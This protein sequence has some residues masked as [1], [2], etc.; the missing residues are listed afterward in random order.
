MNLVV[1]FYAENSGTLDVVYV[2]Y[3]TIGL[4]EYDQLV[5]EN[6]SLTI[7]I[8]RFVS[9]V[10]PLR[11]PTVSVQ[12]AMKYAR[13]SGLFLH[14]STVRVRVPERG[15][16]AFVEIRPYLQTL[17]DVQEVDICGYENVINYERLLDAWVDAQYPLE[18]PVTPSKLIRQ[19]LFAEILGVVP[20][21]DEWNQMRI[22]QLFAAL[23]ETE[24]NDG[25]HGSF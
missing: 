13:E 18:W 4:K 19:R 1:E 16:N 22:Q 15:L 11:Q 6:P 23:K 8:D 20:P 3:S 21:W 12:I 25:F 10:D 17:D 9:V 24:E 2:P 14:T 7:P 5:A